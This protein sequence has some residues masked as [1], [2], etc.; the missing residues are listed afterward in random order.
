LVN[1]IQ[2]SLRTIKRLLATVVAV[3]FVDAHKHQN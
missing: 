3:D 1:A 2:L